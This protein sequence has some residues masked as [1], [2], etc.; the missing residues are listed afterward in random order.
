[1]D[2]LDE[3]FS[4]MRVESA[5]FARLEASAPWGLS[6]R[7]GRTTRF[8]LVL[9]G[10][11][12]LTLDDEKKPVPVA[13]SAGDCFIVPRGQ[14]YTLRDAMGS[15]TVS[16]VDAVRSN[17]G[18]VVALGGGGAATTIVSG[19]FEFDHD[20]ARALLDLLPPLLHIRMDQEGTQRLQAAL[21][22]LA[23]ETAQPALGSGLVVSR[24]ADILFVQA[25]RA[26]IHTLDAQEDS[27]GW[28]AALADRRIGPALHK[29]HRD[30]A[31][32]WTVDMLADAAAM[33][34]SAF[35]A[36]FKAKVGQSPLDY[37]TRWR[38]FRAAHLLRSGDDAVGAIA[39][40]VG[41]ASEPAFNKAFK[42]V[43]GEAPGAYRRRSRRSAVAQ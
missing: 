11:G 18:G 21:Q 20:A 10:G 7:P 16:C 32:A 14:P 6:T 38:M 8:G 5:L 31:A 19:W 35:A 27:A 26:Y 22:L 30:V 42:R 1:M 29:L 17:V 39:G 36:R 40:R 4:A 2:P 12:W 28:L 33:S 24:L 43:V 15:P 34:R 25:V 37:L 13:L 23:V 9:R 3:V 41:Y